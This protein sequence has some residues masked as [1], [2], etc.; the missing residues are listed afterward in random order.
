MIAE[1][2]Q[3]VC[4]LLVALYIPGFLAVELFFSELARLEKFIYAVVISIILDIIVAVSLGYNEAWAAKTGGLTFSNLVLVESVLIAVLLIPY[5]Y[6]IITRKRK[7]RRTLANGT[8]EAKEDKQAKKKPA[9]KPK[10]KEAKKKTKKEVKKDL[11]SIPDWLRPGHPMFHFIVRSGVFFAVLF[12]VYF[13]IFLYFRHTY[14]FITYLSIPEEFYFSFLT[15]LRKRDFINAALFTAVIF[16][17]WNRRHIADIEKYKQNRLETAVFGVLAFLSLGAHYYLKYWIHTNL[18]Q[19]LQYSFI[20]TLLK[21]FFNVAFVVLLA[22]AVYN[23]RFFSDQFNRFKAQLPVFALVLGGYFFVI[24]LFQTVWRTLGNMV[25]GSVHFLLSLSF[26]N[27]ILRLDAM[28]APILGVGSFVA[29]ISEE[30]SGIDSLLLFISLYTVLLVLDW[31]RMDKKK[32]LI[33]FVP[34][35]IGTVGYNILRIYLLFL[36]GVFISPDF[37]ID[38]FHTNIGWIL[39]LGFFILFWH[40][41]SK[42]VYKK[43]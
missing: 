40:Y 28:R 4:G 34:G 13:T 14:F 9:K 11:L 15:G 8:E 2:I 31:D 5:L 19:A 30:C 36:V 3:V 38:M 35:I 39:F 16:F 33:L 41:G 7:L 17:V 32:M 20:L 18:V 37:A 24:Q 6:L 26:D 43:S 22:L 10:K 25:A 29:G 1:L 27:T 42:W 12:A 21:Y 23:V